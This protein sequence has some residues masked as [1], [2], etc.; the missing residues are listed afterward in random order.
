LDLL[1]DDDSA[2]WIESTPIAANCAERSDQS[3]SA[4]S[5]VELAFDVA[6]PLGEVGKEVGE[7]EEPEP[8]PF[9]HEIPTATMPATTIFAQRVTQRPPRFPIVGVIGTSQKFR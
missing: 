1:L 6:P 3:L 8:P 7:L 2:D 5:P 4:G 9:A